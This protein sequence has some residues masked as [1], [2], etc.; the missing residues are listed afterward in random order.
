MITS[1]EQSH[2]SARHFVHISVT[3]LYFLHL[4]QLK[5]RQKILHELKSKSETAEVILSEMLSKHNVRGFLIGS[6]CATRGPSW[7]DYVFLHSIL[8][9]LFLF[10]YPWY[11]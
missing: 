2:C 3:K 9:G 11:I 8:G 4:C 5:E 6:I 10:F 1:K 7:S